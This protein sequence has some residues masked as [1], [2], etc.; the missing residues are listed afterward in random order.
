MRHRIIDE[1]LRD[2]FRQRADQ[3]VLLLGAGFDTRAFRLTGGRRLELDQPAVLAFNLFPAV[4]AGI[5]G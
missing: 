5:L 3:R 4:E 2:R 1:A